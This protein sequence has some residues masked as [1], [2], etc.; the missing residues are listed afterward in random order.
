MIGDPKALADLS[1]MEF[2][3]LLNLVPASEVI[4]LWS[5]R[6]AEKRQLVSSIDANDYTKLQQERDSLVARIALYKATI[7]RYQRL[8]WTAITPSP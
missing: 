2:R 3:A 7:E 4:E 5:M 6:L 1:W 8:R